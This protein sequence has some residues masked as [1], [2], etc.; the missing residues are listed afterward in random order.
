MKDIKSF[1]CR[2]SQASDSC[3]LGNSR[4]RSCSSPCI[5]NTDFQSINFD[6]IEGIVDLSAPL[7]NDASIDPDFYLHLNQADDFLLGKIEG[8]YPLTH[9]DTNISMVS[10]KRAWNGTGANPGLPPTSSLISFLKEKQI[11]SVAVTDFQ[12]QFKSK[13][14]GS[15]F[16]N[17]AL[18]TSSHS[19]KLCGL[20]DITAKLMWSWAN[21]WQTAPTNVA[22]NCSLVMFY[23]YYNKACYFRLECY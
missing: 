23:V 8:N 18:L 21:N 5:H 6:K 1:T 13:L 2:N 3:P 15:E 12:T 7:S 14:F 10:M 16:D 19:L 20:V 22:A 17:G 9:T 4:V 11:Q